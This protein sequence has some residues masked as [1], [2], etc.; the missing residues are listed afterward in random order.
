MKT[1]GIKIVCLLVFTAIGVVSL[2]TGNG[3]VEKVSSISSGP[4]AGFSGA[5]DEN[6]CAAC[7]SGP[8]PNGQ[9]EILDA[10]TSYRPGQTY[11]LRVRHTNADVT[12]LRWGFEMTGLAGQTAAGTFGNLGANT[13]V[14]SEDGRTYIEQTLAGTFTDQTG[15]A[16]WTVNWIAPAANLGP[17][18]LYAAGIQANH[19]GG[20]SGDQPYT[21][22]V[23]MAA[24]PATA[25]DFDGDS[26]SDVS[27]FR[28]AVGEW[29]VS[30]SS[31]G[32]NF[33]TQ[34][35]SSAD[36]TVPADYTGDGKA[37]IAF[38]QTSTGFWYVLRSDDLTF[39]AFPFGTGSDVPAPA[40]Y[41]GDGKAD[42]AVFRAST[43][44][45]YISNSGGGTTIQQFGLTTDLPVPA[46]YDG[47]GKTDIAIYR[48]TGANG[49]EWW[50]LKSTGGSFATQFGLP[51]DK[52]VPGDY[53]GDGK[54]DVAY[55]RPSTGEW[56]I[57]RS[58]DLTFYAFPFG[59]GTDAA[60]PGDYDGDGKTDAAVFR[61]SSSTWYLNRSTAG[62]LIQQFGQ[63]GD[64]P[65]P[66]AFVR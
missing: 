47:D 22:N 49:A 61:P 6:N 39:Y 26:K 36:K 50:I 63:S 42:A 16:L 60:V 34:F 46:D 21:T 14:L 51:T 44:T 12:R 33:A 2:M 24:P 54:A 18:T 9:F 25:F 31:N 62:V 43:A 52:A 40:D 55:W 20:P 5:P 7:H 29:W 28:P 56:F 66:N 64:L 8:T 65:L 27:I 4:P 53:T 13:Q 3:L 30:K 1:R 45:W 10:P 35:G 38:F 57:L 37:D 59:S 15:G 58:E 19:A 11:Q 41:D 32:G 48:P 17:V 23:T